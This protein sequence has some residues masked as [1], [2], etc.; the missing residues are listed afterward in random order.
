MISVVVPAYNEA[1]H[2]GALLD[3]LTRQTTR[4]RFE[5]IV[6]D[7]AS[8]DETAAVA[9][10]WADRLRLRVIAEP[11]RSRG[12][13][14]A[15]GFAAAKGAII[16]ST[17]TDTTVPPQWVERLA[18]AVEQPGVVAVT[19]TCRIEDCAPRTNRGFNLLQPWAMR[20]YR[21]V[22]GHYWLTGSNSALQRVAY[23]RSGGYSADAVDLDDIEL[24][25]RLQHEG[26]IRM[27]SDVPV[28]TSG[29][30][31]RRGL[32]RGLWPYAAVFFRRF[33]FGQASAS[34]D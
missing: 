33:W 12:A 10:R 14:R 18:T 30:R 27:V 20:V 15:A 32:L 24:G 4:R 9:R 7:N 17:D 29:R 22:Y 34:R 11:V 19:G 31:F 13:A 25:F 1:A 23:E 16:L 21:L 8:T 28:T 6:V 26:R 5:V 3:S 2:I